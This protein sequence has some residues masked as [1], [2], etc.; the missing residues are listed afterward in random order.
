MD[1]YE[2]KQKASVAIAEMIRDGYAE[3][4]IVNKIEHQFGFSEKWTSSRIDKMDEAE[5]NKI[6][7]LD[8]D[9]VKNYDLWKRIPLTII[10]KT[11][12]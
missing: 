4:E 3:I 8:N 12:K 10:F 6:P 11:R 5:R 9:Y 2:R 1:F 7:Y